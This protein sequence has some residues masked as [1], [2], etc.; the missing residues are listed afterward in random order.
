MKIL[1]LEDNIQLAE[2]IGEY[3]EGMGCDIDYAYT[4]ASC[5]S[6]VEQNQYD[7]LVLD[8]AMPGMTGL[9]AC[10]QIRQH[11]QVATPLIFLTAR[12]TLDDKL[13]GYKAGGDDYLIKPFAPEELLRRLQALSL[14]GP[15]RDLGIVKI[16]PLEVNY[17][18][19]SV[20]RDGK[21]IALHATQFAILKLLTQ[22]YPHTV[23]R[24]RVERTIWG[25]NPP[26]SDAL[27]THMYRLR[28]LLDKPF[29]LPL[30]LTI[31]GKGYRL[32]TYE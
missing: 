7:V 14:R 1:L 23:S 25:D 30:I 2:S 21:T 8:I 19:H 13:A 24:E 28:N 18:N 12:D 29:D 10:D 32:E 3:L 11:L 17:S 5:V 31:H 22:N 4:A 9:E 6:F 15:R 26:D 27:R 20:I 16:G